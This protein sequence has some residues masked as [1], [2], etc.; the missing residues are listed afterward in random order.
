[1]VSKGDHTFS[2]DTVFAML[3][4]L[5]LAGSK[6]TVSLVRE[7]FPTAPYSVISAY[8]SEWSASFHSSKSVL[9]KY[10]PPPESVS[11][12]FS[13]IW[14]Q[15]RLFC[16]ETIASERL[17]LEALR[18][19]LEQ[20]KLEMLNEIQRLENAGP[21]QQALNESFDIDERNKLYEELVS[22]NNDIKAAKL[23]QVETVADKLRL[24][25][26][27]LSF[28]QEKTRLHKELDLKSD[29][30]DKLFTEKEALQKKFIDDDLKK[31]RELNETKEAL[32]I[33]Y[34]QVETL[35][36]QVETLT[37]QVEQLNKIE[38]SSEEVI[39]F[40][41]QIESLH[42]EL[43]KSKDSLEEVRL[44]EKALHNKKEHFFEQRVQDQQ[45][46]IDLDTRYTNAKKRLF[47]HLETYEELHTKLARLEK[48]LLSENQRHMKLER[49]YAQVKLDL[50]S[51]RKIVEH[52][53]SSR[54][55]I[56]SLTHKIQLLNEKESQ[57][58]KVLKDKNNR[59]N[60]ILKRYEKIKK[61]NEALRAA[62]NDE[63][64]KK[65]IS[66]QTLPK[67]YKKDED[68]HQPAQMYTIEDKEKARGE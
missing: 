35:S 17:E 25:R 58:R 12:S 65:A 63:E 1:M 54:A 26:E 8:I 44:E 16:D 9:D 5:Q 62:N 51:A 49:D 60:L 61:E 13:R 66:L 20:E 29:L 31:S 32:S 40:Q 6:P 27:A 3:D 46:Y 15:S 28:E 38:E 48:K 45:S 22:L 57:F 23:N 64:S 19:E 7:R 11:Q 37:L 43:S 33:A 56:E 39:D 59:Y 2:K 4:E 36:L 55:E 21:P 24:E 47:E 67:S 14:T 50:D 30:V 68:T 34:G 42:E 52:P 10:P 18:H 41:K 53:S